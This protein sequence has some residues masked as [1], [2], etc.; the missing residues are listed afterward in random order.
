MKKLKIALLLFF[1]LIVVLI[2]SLCLINILFPGTQSLQSPELSDE[3]YLSV[4][5]LSEL[6]TSEPD[7]YEVSEKIEDVIREAI[8]VKTNSGGNLPE[9][10][11]YNKSKDFYEWLPCGD[12]FELSIMHNYKKAIVYYCFGIY[13]INEENEKQV[14]FVTNKYMPIRIYCEKNDDE[15]AI[16]GYWE[17]T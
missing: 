15:W 17:P 14:V 16:S 9:E 8:E 11:I 1:V 3:E 5:K 4:N 2:I 10:Y 13:Y 6:P 7:Y 12:V